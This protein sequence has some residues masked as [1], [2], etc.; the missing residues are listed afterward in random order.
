MT[1]RQVYQGLT[2]L[3]TITDEAERKL[4][5]PSG[6][7]DIPLVIQDR[8]FTSGNQLHYSLTMRQRMQGFL[9]DTILVNGQRNHVIPVKTRAYRLRILNGSNAR[10]Y[11]LGW[12][13]GSP[14]TAIGTDGG[15]LEK[16]ETFPYIMLSPAER[17]ELWVDFSG[18]KTGSELALQT[19]PYQGFSMGMGGGMRGGRGGMGMQ[20]GAVDQ[21]SKDT[22]VR[23]TITEQVSDS[24]KLPDTLV[25]IHRLTVKDVSN[26][27]K[28]V[29]INIG[30]RRMTF[31][32]NGRIFEMLDY[33][34]QER[35]PLNTVQKIRISN[36]NPAM[37]GGMGRGMRGGQG[38]GMMGMMRALPH[39]IHLH[40]QQFQI[41]SRKPGY[42]D[43]AY[44]TVKDGFINSGWKDTVLV[45][46]GE[47]V[48]IIKP[49]M[50][51]TGLF[52]YHCH[53]L[54]HEDMGMM[55]NFFVS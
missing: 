17:V 12:S 33:T 30:M 15:L 55:R 51:Y 44:A 36:A 47:E 25:P 23:F 26:P 40:G 27:D 35:I 16:P 46:P 53:N 10:I 24:P 2:G 5:L 50:D 9:G 29:P 42:A 54:E 13:D 37:G 22:L 3:I 41:L 28:T 45:M 6:E 20:E 21:G 7:F 38:G 39:P 1:A 8:S 19:L 52:L 49:F 11:K 32:L 14:I 43:N 4:D 31:N 48:E 18:H 34:E